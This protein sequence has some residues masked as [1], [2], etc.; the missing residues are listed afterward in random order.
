M[1]QKQN[2]NSFIY[3]RSLNFSHH[4]VSWYTF[5]TRFEGLPVAHYAGL[6]RL[7]LPY[8][9]WRRYSLI[10]LQAAATDLF[11]L[12]SGHTALQATQLPTEQIPALPRRLR[13]ARLKAN[14]LMTRWKMRGSITLLP[15]RINFNFK[16]TYICYKP[17]GRDSSVIIATPY[18]LDGP[19]IESLWGRDFPHPSRPVLRPIQPTIQLVPGLS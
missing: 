18:G 7:R 16:F 1:N 12:P 3:C 19:G 11:V 15:H 17:V 2:Y 6:G 4:P 5:R 8:E 14:Q 9:R 13:G 10:Q